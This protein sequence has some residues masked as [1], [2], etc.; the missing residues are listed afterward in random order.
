M[1]EVETSTSGSSPRLMD[2]RE[3]CATTASDRQAQLAEALAEIKGLRDREK[4]AN[5]AGH[6]SFSSFSCFFFRGFAIVF[7]GFC[8]FFHVFFMVFAPDVAGEE[9]ISAVF[10][11]PRAMRWA[12][13]FGRCRVKALESLVERCRRP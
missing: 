8:L 1:R 10:G 12:V 11:W 2:E 7:H 6:G 5:Q 3:S 13:P 4:L 9:G